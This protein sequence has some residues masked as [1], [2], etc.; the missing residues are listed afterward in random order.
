MTDHT[1]DILRRALADAADA[2]PGAAVA[3][4]DL[5]PRIRRRRLAGTVVAAALL[6]APLGVALSALDRSPSGTDRVAAG[7]DSS[8]SVPPTAADSPFTGAPL[9]G[10]EVVRGGSVLALTRSPATPSGTIPGI[11]Q[12]WPAPVRTR[13]GLLIA[14]GDQVDHHRIALVPP[15]GPERVLAP[16]AAGMAVDRSGERVAWAVAS[17]GGR[18]AEVVEAT[19]DGRVRNRVSLDR[20]ARVV[21]YAGDVV[22]LETGDGAASAAATWVPGAATVRRL[23]DVPGL[24]FYGKVLA[25]DPEYRSAV[26]SPGDGGGC[27]TLAD[28]RSD[29]TVGPPRATG[30]CMARAGEGR[31]G[32]GGTTVALPSGGSGAGSVDVVGTDGAAVRSLEPAGN[33]LQVRWLDDDTLLVLS[34]LGATVDLYRCAVSSGSCDRSWSFPTG[35]NGVTMALVLR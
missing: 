20:F 3:P 10:V 11:I 25:T 13:L 16:D 31:F 18:A 21:G 23:V 29:G 15:V 24:G 14:I 9:A 27:A 8:T 30:S 17:P 5:R 33:P 22:V 19:L 7:P 4:A 6:L 32:P 1:E 35:P 28:V 2:L 26:F 12:S 34:D